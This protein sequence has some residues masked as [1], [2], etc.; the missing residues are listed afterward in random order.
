M[1]GDQ[2]QENR[3]KKWEVISLMEKRNLKIKKV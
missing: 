2:D 3:S 1:L